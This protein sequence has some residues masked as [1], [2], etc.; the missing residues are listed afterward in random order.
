[1]SR[2]P[3]L[4]GIVHMQNVHAMMNASTDNVLVNNAK[5]KTPR[6]PNQ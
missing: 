1:M 4:T 3:K 5:R 6:Q 2:N